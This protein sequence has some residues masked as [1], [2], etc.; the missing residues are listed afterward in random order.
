MPE[1]VTLGEALI[2]FVA[3]EA[4]VT[5]AD[6]SGFAKAAGGAPANVAC[7][8]AK[9]GHSAAFI[10]KV[11][12]DPFGSFLE[13]TFSGA[14]VDT[15]RMVFSSEA[16][17]GLAFVALGPDRVPDFT[18]YRSP[19]A[20]MLLS[21]DEL[22]EPFIRGAEIFHYGSI[23][24][25][26]EPSRSATVRAAD[27]AR[28]AGLI[29]SY[30]P[31]L[32]PSL[33]VSLDAAKS[34]MLEGLKGANLLKV[35]AE[36]L[37]FLTCADSLD[38]GTGRLLKDYPTLELIVVTTGGDG[39]YYRSRKASGKVKGCKV[40]VVDTTG[41]GD[42]FVAGVLSQLLDRKL[43]S[44]KLSSLGKSELD[45]I[46]QYANAVGALATTQKGAIASMPTKQDVANFLR[47]L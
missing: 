24:L 13:N 15:S 42:G 8:A 45:D 26:A 16:K 41:A 30:D 46:C 12:E 6:A 10:G 19:S 23:S 38:E 27:I 31:N 2:D 29:V 7:G 47:R 28:S 43:T 25:I 9:L 3:L 21:A 11:G 1:I 4:G 20:D 37:V 18:F 34:G 35:S 14:G 36:E 32:R 33:W 39:C 22:D 5:L 17:T 44:G 40:D